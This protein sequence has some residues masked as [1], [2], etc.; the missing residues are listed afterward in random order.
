LRRWMT[1]IARKKLKSLKCKNKRKKG[2]KK[3]SSS[4]MRPS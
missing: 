1:W 3:A 4:R 2:K